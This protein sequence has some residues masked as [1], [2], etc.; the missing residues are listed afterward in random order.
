METTTRKTSDS[1]ICSNAS[2]F[3]SDYWTDGSEVSQRT[4]ALNDWILGAFLPGLMNERILEVGVGGEGGLI[5][6]LSQNNYVCGVDVSESAIR[7]CK[8]MGLDVTLCDL[9]SDPLP[10]QEG[11]FQKIVALE[12]F[13][14]FSNPQKALE[15]IRRVLC[16]GGVVL[17][18]LPT[19]WSYHWPRCFYPELIY[20][21]GAFLRFL[22]ANDFYVSRQ[23]TGIV[24]CN[25]HRDVPDFCKA[26]NR[27]FM[28]RKI[29]DGDA[30]LYFEN[31]LYFWEQI[32]GYGLRI[33]PVTAIDLFRKSYVCSNSDQNLL[34]LTHS[35]LYRVINCEIDEFKKLFQQVLLRDANIAAEEREDWRDSFAQL[36]LEAHLLGVPLVDSQEMEKVRRY[37]KSRSKLVDFCSRLTIQL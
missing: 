29:G 18:S 30:R 4:H 2:A 5:L 13:E 26:Q 28:C 33:D 24:P 35:L 17:I 32:D 27:F 9:N 36:L 16:D 23:E 8:N 25:V 22:M 20:H 6:G 31:A 12:V 37:A 15:E 21:E 34:A 19:P 11:Y 1:S 3:Y 14:H 10:F 7:N